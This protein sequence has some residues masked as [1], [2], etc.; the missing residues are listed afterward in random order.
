MKNKLLITLSAFLL[1]SMGMLAQDKSKHKENFFGLGRA[2]VSNETLSDSTS[3]DKNAT[4]NGYTL[5]DLGVKMQRNDIFKAHAIL[6]VRNE[7]GGFYGD[8]VSFD[9]RE[10]RLEGLI[11][12]MIKY[13]IGDLDVSL[14]PYTIHNA[15]PSF[16]EYE[17]ELFK[18]K[19]D[20]IKYENFYTDENSWRMQGVNAYTTLKLQSNLVKKLYVRLFGN[21]VAPTN[22]V[23]EGDRFVWG[24][25]LDFINSKDMR[26]GINMANTQDLALTV[27]DASVNYDN[28]VITSDFRFV[29][30]LNQKMSLGLEGEF[31]GSQYKMEREVDAEATEYS[32][33]FYDVKAVFGYKPLGLEVKAGYKTVGQNFSSPTAQTRRIDDLA[34]GESLT[35]YPTYNDGTTARKQSIFDRYSQESGLYRRSISTT[36]DPFSPIYGNINPYGAATPNRTG[37]TLDVALEDSLKRWEGV[38]K[39]QNQQEF[40]G[41][42]VSAKRK[43]SG[44]IIGAKFNINRFIGWNKLF[45]VYGSYN[46]ESTKRDAPGVGVDLNTNVIDLS[47]DAEV[48]NRLHLL[49]GMKS[50]GAKG[51]EFDIIR[52]DF[53][54]I[55][56]TELPN[57][58]NY[59]WSDQVIVLGAKYDFGPNSFLG[60]STQFTSFVDLSTS[61]EE[62]DYNLDQIYI[63][64]QIKF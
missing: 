43:F 60:L 53:N 57:Q 16:Y 51:T 18:M 54:N 37:L 31:G 20:V 23:D 33:G 28:F 30:S 22:N 48:Y 63:I 62:D 13:E 26:I 9:F 12:K 42:N 34:Q 41:Q 39:Y 19:R 32:D 2:V 14:T 55:S 24:G 7:F 25:K 47:L 61:F 44:M 45:A 46:G 40:V 52:D 17:N 27:P 50:L 5:F 56:E 29:K 15:E 36:L 11:S 38:V 3:E 64:Y 35:L 1:G 4:T 10:L 59:D 58:K 6:R 49:A 21:R 8:G